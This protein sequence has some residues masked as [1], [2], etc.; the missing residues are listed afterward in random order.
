MLE[1]VDAN[2]RTAVIQAIA[3][4]LADAMNVELEFQLRRSLREQ[5]IDGQ[6]PATPAPVQ[7]EQLTPP[8]R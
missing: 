2:G 6:R 3:R 1:N 8:R 5:L 4:D 7:Q